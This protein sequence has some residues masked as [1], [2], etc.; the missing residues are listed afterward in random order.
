MFGGAD[1][2]L[3]IAAAEPQIVSPMELR[4]TKTSR[5]FELAIRC[6]SLATITA[7]RPQ[8]DQLA[9]DTQGDACGYFCRRDGDGRKRRVR[10]QT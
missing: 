10:Q 6:S 9:N 5:A 3:S 2:N 1:L 4:T 7:G 8:A